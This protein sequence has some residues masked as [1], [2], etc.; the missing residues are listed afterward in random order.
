MPRGFFTLY[1]SGVQTQSHWKFVGSVGQVSP[2]CDRQAPM[3]PEA[4]QD[5]PKLAFL[6]GVT[7]QVPQW[8]V[9]ETGGGMRPGSSAGDVAPLA[10]VM[11]EQREGA[12]AAGA[13]SAKAAEATQRPAR[14]QTTRSILFISSPFQLV[15]R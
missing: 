3:C 15:K 10:E 13:P 12:A 7:L 14:A 5:W 2:L 1:Y 11:I 6:Q 9:R 8:V 4:A